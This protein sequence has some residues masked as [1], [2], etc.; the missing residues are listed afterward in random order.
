MRIRNQCLLVILGSPFDPGRC[1]EPDCNQCDFELVDPNPAWRVYRHSRTPAHCQR[2][3]PPPGRTVMSGCTRGPLPCPVPW[4]V[5]AEDLASAAIPI[6]SNRSN[7]SHRCVRFAGGVPASPAAAGAPCELGCPAGAA[8]S[9]R[10]VGRCTRDNTTAALSYVG[11][12]VVCTQC[13]AGRYLAQDLGASGYKEA[14]RPP[15]SPTP[16][17]LQS[18]STAFR[19]PP[20][21]V[22][23]TGPHHTTQA[24]APTAPLASTRRMPARAAL[25]A[26]KASRRRCVLEQTTNAPA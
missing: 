3:D 10:T 11:Q 7:L 8:A 1:T 24:T 26:R 19:C 5:A 23:V 12:E 22:D 14:Q 18:L 25:T 9:A 20:I 15:S 6:D 13:A 17:R 21:A 2:F 4:P 16:P